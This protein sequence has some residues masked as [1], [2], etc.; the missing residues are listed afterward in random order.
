MSAKL[1]A[2]PAG[3]GRSVHGVPAALELPTFRIADTDDYREVRALVRRKELNTVCQEAECPNIF[4][5][6]GRERTATF[7]LMGDVCTRR[8]G[9]CAIAQGAGR[10]LDPGEPRRVAGAGAALG[11][12]HA[13]VTSVDRD[14]LPDGGAAHFASTIREIRALVPGVTVEVLVPDFLGS[15]AALATVLAARPEVLNHNVETVGRL[16][17]RVRPDAVYGRSL[18]LLRRAAAFRDREAPAMRTKSGLMV[19]LGETPD[20]LRRTLRDLRANGTDVVTVGQYLPPH[21]RRLPVERYWTPEEF[22]ELRRFGEEIGFRRIE[23]GPLV[24]SSYHARRA[25]G[26]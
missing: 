6:W 17:R 4:E 24:R 26:G 8:C 9:F 15:E 16:Y 1:P 18:E 21:E 20:E 22:E 10:A 5:C 25:L 19:G 7:L 23:S 2:V 13:V 14:D 11:E 12:A 3:P